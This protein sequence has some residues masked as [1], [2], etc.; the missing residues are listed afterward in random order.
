MILA[1]KDKMRIKANLSGSN[2]SKQAGV[3]QTVGLLD[4]QRGFTLLE[5]IIVMA[6]MGIVAAIAIPSFSAGIEKQAVRN[7]AQTLLSHMK[8]ARVRALAENRTVKI[9]F[10]V[11]ASGTAADAYMFDAGTTGA[12][13]KV[14]VMYSNFSRNL[15]LT[16]ND[17]TK[18]PTTLNFKS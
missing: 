18:N 17:P 14:L 11:D 12:E 2:Q 16:K 13:K 6:I 10:G 9:Q 1:I 7:A 8:Q 5:V 4:R 15:K 3:L